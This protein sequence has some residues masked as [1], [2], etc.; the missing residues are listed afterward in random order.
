MV[1][2]F[3]KT[4]I[5]Y[6]LRG[7]F[8]LAAGQ[9]VNALI[10][11]ALAVIFANFLPKEIYGV[12][13]YLLSLA[14]VISA[15]TLTGLGTAVVRAVARGFDGT[16]R[17]AFKTKM[18]W[19]ATA[20]LVALGGSFYYFLHNNYTLALSLLVI[21]FT[22][23][24]IESGK[25]FGHS[26]VGKKDF[27]RSAIAS[28]LYNFVPAAALVFIVFFT[29]KPV[30]LVLA[31]FSLSAMIALLLYQWSL[32]R[33]TNNRVDDQAINYGKKLT[34]IDLTA[35][36]AAYFD[37]IVVFHFLGAASL[38]AYSLAFVVPNK[39]KGVLRLPGQL[40]LPKFS[41]RKPWEIKADLP[42]RLAVMSGIIFLVMAAYVL[43]TPLIFQVAFPKYQESIFYSQLAAL[44]MIGSLMP[45][46]N[47]AWSAHRRVR[48]MAIINLAD[49][50]LKVL[51]VIGLGYWLGLLGVVVARVVA[52]WLL[53]GLSVSLYFFTDL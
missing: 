14:G 15:F 28:V 42:R 29:Q 36:V 52:Q 20:W 32:K 27:R 40:A 34:L 6:L 17:L 26:F 7:G 18:K 2:R 19:S 33:L 46:I 10:G 45:V 37:Q 16:V 1:E 35:G 39:I 9:L 23:P 43:L 38:A 47:A 51:L 22:L 3:V 4:D 44:V 48:A 12:Y 13:R 50:L 5:R 53:V 8:W 24:L 11:L 49:P 25:L 30:W 21:S 41:Q 31:Y